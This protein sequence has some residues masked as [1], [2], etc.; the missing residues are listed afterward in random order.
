MV[1]SI[2]HASIMMLP[3]ILLFAVLH[4]SKQCPTKCKCRPFGKNLRVKC[5]GID[6]VPKG[7][8]P[9]TLTLN[10]SGNSLKAIREGAFEN[11]PLLAQL[12]LS[13]NHLKFIAKNAFKNLTSLHLLSM[14][15]CDLENIESG[16][17]SRM[18]NLSRLSLFAN[19]LSHIQRGTFQ[20]IG[21]NLYELYLSSNQILSVDDGTFEQLGPLGKLDLSDNSLS[22]APDLTGLNSSTYVYLDQNQITDV[23]PLGK[24]GNMEFTGLKLGNNRIEYIPPDVFQKITIK[25][26]LTADWLAQLVQ[27]RAPVRDLSL[28]KLR[29]IPQN[30]FFRSSHLS[31][32]RLVKNL[33]KK[34]PGRSSPR[35]S[36]ITRKGKSH[37]RD[38]LNFP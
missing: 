26:W 14:G 4:G 25:G 30:L 35:C 22:S 36:P 38:G 8:P 28:N 18:H 33:L 12:D 23:R 3:L 7:I 9:N 5:E 19:K 29:S 34:G 1:R 24:S 10:L 13:R 17:F 11:L 15:N 31:F 21:S 6:L 27:L 16:T 20:G 2:W 32:L 37:T